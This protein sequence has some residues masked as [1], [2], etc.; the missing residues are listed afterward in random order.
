MKS[1]T[2]VGAIVANAEYANSVLTITIPRQE[3]P[4]GGEASGIKVPIQQGPADRPLKR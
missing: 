3:A 1:K 4:Q 2:V